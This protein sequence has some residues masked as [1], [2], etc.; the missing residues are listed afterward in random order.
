M[1]LGSGKG[2]KKVINCEKRWELWIY[3]GNKLAECMTEWRPVKKSVITQV[4][5][6]C[7]YDI[8]KRNG[9]FRRRRWVW[10]ARVRLMKST[11]CSWKL[12]KG[13]VICIE[14]YDMH[15]WMHVEYKLR[16]T[17][18]G[19]FENNIKLIAITEVKLPWEYIVRLWQKIQ[20]TIK[21]FKWRGLNEDT[22]TKVQESS[23]KP[24]KDLPLRQT[25]REA[26]TI[27]KP[28]RTCDLS[29]SQNMQPL[30]QLTDTFPLALFLS[31]CVLP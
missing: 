27:P 29:C 22:I 4:S 23:R 24:T 18:F 19:L 10:G 2:N 9:E 16:G 25:I 6:L 7:E 3:T 5:N 31:H 21:R 12:S 13:R 30:P 8:L 14:N 1:E 11:E 28:G 20:G 17:S 15:T 26:V